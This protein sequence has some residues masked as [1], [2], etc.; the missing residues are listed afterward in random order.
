MWYDQ[1]LKNAGI[2]SGIHY[3]RIIPDQAALA[4]PESF[5][6]AAEPVNARRLAASQLSLPVHS[7]L[8][9]AEVAA[10]ISCCNAFKA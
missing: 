8:E 9:E 4:A 5:V 6:M 10:I 1:Y 3:P 2:E 7:F